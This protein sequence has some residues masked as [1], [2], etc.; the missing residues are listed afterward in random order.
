MTAVRPRASGGGVVYWEK[1]GANRM[2]A[3]H[4]INSLLQGPVYNE[5]E[6]CKIGHE[7]DRRERQ[8]MAEGADASAYNDFFEGESGN[9]AHDGFFNVSVLM[10]CLRRQHIQCLSTSKPEVREVLANPG[11]E[12]GFIFNL[13]EHWFTIRKVEGTWYNLDSLKPSPVAVSPEQLKNLLTSLTL[14]GYVSFVA[15]RDVGPLPSPQPQQVQMHQFYLTRRDMEALQAQAR[16]KE[17]EDAKKAAAHADDSDSGRSFLAWAPRG[18]RDEHTWPSEGGYRLDA[19]N[20]SA[21]AAPAAAQ[22]SP[23]P[24]GIGGD[25]GDLDDDPELREALRLSLETYKQEMQAPPEEPP[26]D[27]Q[28]ICTLV[29]RLRNGERVTRRFRKA[30][31]MEHVFQWAEYEASRRSPTP[32][33]SCVLVQTVPRRKFCKL[34][35]QISLCEADAEGVSVK[36]RDLQDLGFQRREQL[37]MMQ[38]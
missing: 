32:G 17:A 38:L 33:A 19:P 1:Q 15:R 24:S 12:E 20:G 14:Q 21:A 23:E 26:E 28:D 13:N 6:M 8:L 10:E 16:A 37:M 11:R 35:G 9:V 22:S 7:F 36:G 31:T 25:F 18:K 30:D 3:L 5:T 27:A 4:C 2:C 34:S 29:I